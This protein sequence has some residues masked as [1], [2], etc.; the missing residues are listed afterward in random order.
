MSDRCRSCGAP[1]LWLTNEKTGKPAP[2][3]AA[4]SAIGNVALVTGDRYA[5]LA[6][7][8]L[9]LAREGGAELRTNHWITCTDADEW[10]A[11][12]KR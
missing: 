9:T 12:A 2:I 7:G 8:A 11:K 3:D 1:I 5:V 4:P 10:K 6:K